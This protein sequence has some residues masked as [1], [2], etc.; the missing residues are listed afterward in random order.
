MRGR[1]LLQGYPTTREHND[2]ARALFERAL[3]I[4]PNDAA[5]LAA[6]ART[7]TLDLY[8]D[9]QIRRPITTLK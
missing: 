2:A 8:T 6:N 3:A 5:A 7:Y 1:A 4:D 9:G